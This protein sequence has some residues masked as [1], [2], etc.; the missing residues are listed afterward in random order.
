MWPKSSAPAVRAAS[1]KLGGYLYP[2][3]SIPMT[4]S[5]W[6]QHFGLKW[7]F[8]VTA[9]RRYDPRGILTPGQGIFAPAG[10]R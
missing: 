8:L 4:P 5:D 3:G 9:R 6:Q 1:L 7:Q 10:N 2:I